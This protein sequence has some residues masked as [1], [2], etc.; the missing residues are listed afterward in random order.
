MLRGII[1]DLD[2]TLISLHVDGTAFRR[3]IARELTHSGFRMD[4][5]EVSSG[6][7]YIQDM[8]DL[9]KSQIDQGQVMVD[10]D[11][12][13][14][15]TFQALDELEVGWIRHSQLLPGAEALLTRLS[16]E[17]KAPITLALLTNSGRAA[18]RYAMETLG[19]KRY[20]QKT[21]TRDD[22]PAMKPRPQGITAALKTLGLG[23]GEVLYV[24]DS[25]TDIIAARGAG[26]RIASVASGRYDV[27]ALRKLG[28]DFVL[29]SLSELEGLVPRLA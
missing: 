18:T 17:G 22:L 6:G 14:R 13:R 7:L 2:G 25:P 3:E 15:R 21:F 5:I 1:F 24:G 28:P 20:F 9:A 12:V 8:L 16:G 4:L 11:G 27:E 10:Y 19:F 26:I 23:E 29:G